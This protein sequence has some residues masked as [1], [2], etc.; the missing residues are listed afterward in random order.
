MLNIVD[1]IIDD[2]E[3][4]DACLSSD[5]ANVPAQAPSQL[6][7]RISPRTHRSDLD[8]PSGRRGHLV[9]APAFGFAFDAGTCPCPRGIAGRLKASDALRC[10]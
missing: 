3:R 6:C 4:L 7:R 1:D 10:A 5:L 9:P 8:V 2:D